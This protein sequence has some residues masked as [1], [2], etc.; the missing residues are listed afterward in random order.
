MTDMDKQEVLNTLLQELGKR[1]GIDGL[2]TDDKGVCTLSIDEHLLLNFLANPKDG[3]LIIWC[4]V[5]EVPSVDYL[6]NRAET[7]TTLLRTNLFWQ[8]TGGATLSMMPD[9]DDIILANRYPLLDIDAEQLQQITEQLVEQAERSMQL[10][11]AET[12]DSSQDPPASSEH[13]IRV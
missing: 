8:E 7:L 5:G 10:L 4:V 13:F 3:N 1:V 9:S 11:T 2:A 12:S 6:N